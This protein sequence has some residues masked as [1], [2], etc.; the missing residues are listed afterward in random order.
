MAECSPRDKL[1]ERFPDE[2][3]E[4]WSRRLRREYARETRGRRRQ[5]HNEVSPEED[6]HLALGTEGY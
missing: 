5:R 3:E 1:L 6:I 4:A 2:T